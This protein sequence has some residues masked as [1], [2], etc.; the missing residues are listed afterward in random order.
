MSPIDDPTAE[1]E[2]LRR[3]VAELEAQLEERRHNDEVMERLRTI[4]ENT[5]DLIST[6]DIEGRIVYANQ[7]ARR[8]LG[9]PAD[10][11]L[12]DLRVPQFH[13]DWAADLILNEA[14]PHAAREGHWSGET[15]VFG[16]QG[17]EVPVAQS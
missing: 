6:A 14:L 15:A 2:L 5:P 7:S 16:V 9:A 17:R 13:P 12:S 1:I 10:A 3:R 11:A 4:I 8:L